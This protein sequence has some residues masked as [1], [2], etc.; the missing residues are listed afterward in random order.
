MVE[1]AVALA[2]IFFVAGCVVGR[3]GRD[4]GSHGKAKKAPG[5]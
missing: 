2:A 3:L 4:R 5:K 1:A